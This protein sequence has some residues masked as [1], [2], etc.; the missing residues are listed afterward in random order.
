MSSATKI[1]LVDD[2]LLFRE[3]IKLLIETEGMGVVIAEAPNGKVFL[4]MLEPLDPDLVL[5]DIEMPVMGGIEATA[6]ALALKPALKVLL[7]TMLDMSNDYTKLINTGAMGCVLKSAGKKELENA[8]KTVINGE[9]YFSNEL[10]RKIILDFGKQ[11][12]AATLTSS[13]GI[14]C[15]ERELEVLRYLCEG[16]SVTEIADKISRSVKTVEA[17]RAKLLQKTETRNTVNLILFAI[18]NKLVEI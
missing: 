18:K 11:K 16:Y 13:G 9:S 2:H 3:G 6:K 14:E 17:H 5:M 15:S 4:D 10:L 1:I 12:S 8:I 7:V